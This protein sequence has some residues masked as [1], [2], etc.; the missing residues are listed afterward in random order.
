[1]QA[2]RA[3]AALVAVLAFGAHA[4]FPQRT[5]TIVV[6]FTPGTGAD[7]I[8]RLMQ[9]KLAQALKVPV[10]VDNR[11]GASGAI[12]TDF[13]ANAPADGHTLLFTATS[14]GT[15][16]ALRKNLPFD[17]VKS[18]TPVALAATSAM[19]FVVASDLSAKTFDDFVSLAKKKPGELY[20]SSPGN[21]S[22]QHMAMELVK[23]ET[24]MDIVHVPYKGSAG[25][26]TDLMGGR[27]QATVA[28]LQTMA[29]FV[30]GGKLRMLAVFSDERSPA[31]PDVPTMKELG[32]PRLVVDTWYGVFA[33]AGTPREAVL[34]LNGEMNEILKA[35]ETREA[36]ARQG[37]APVVDRPERLGQLVDSELARWNRVVSQAK[38][39]GE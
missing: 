11:A 16:P 38:I 34:R 21:G 3:L 22:I 39:Q 35:P 24:G 25:A 23:I 32:H 20:Y 26:A 1:M 2:W 36:L 12:G 7:L 5:V 6:P 9:P 4:Q 14:H 15:V 19:A 17:P 18:F 13:V 28:A 31:F 29:P 33:P 8:A 37:L 27:V 10:V 30:Q